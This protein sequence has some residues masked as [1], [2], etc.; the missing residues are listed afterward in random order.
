MW[1]S[2]SNIDIDAAILANCD[3]IAPDDWSD[4]RTAEAFDFLVKFTDS[5]PVAPTSAPMLDIPEMVD[6]LAMQSSLEPAEFERLKTLREIRDSVK[7]TRVNKTRA[8]L[9]A[10]QDAEYDESLKADRLKAI[11][12]AI[13]E[14][15]EH[16]RSAREAQEAQEALERE[17]QEALERPEREAK[18]AQERIMF[19]RKKRCAFFVN[20]TS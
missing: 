15:E 5:V 16:E 4:E 11:E 9:R 2:K 20:K 7:N 12:K 18:E 14:K 6:I 10:R 13:K 17:A 8:E 19:L 1:E 3:G